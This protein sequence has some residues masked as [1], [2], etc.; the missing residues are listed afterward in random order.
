MLFYYCIMYNYNEVTICLSAVKKGKH[1]VLYCKFLLFDDN[2]YSYKTKG[3]FV[4]CGFYL[5]YPT[6]F[7]LHI[8]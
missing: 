5:A 8:I 1:V 3:A 4:N 6:D 2:T 7:L